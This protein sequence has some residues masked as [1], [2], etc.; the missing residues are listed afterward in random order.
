M[1]GS[2][3]ETKPPSEAQSTLR[4]IN[5][6]IAK[7]YRTISFEARRNSNRGEDVPVEEKTQHRER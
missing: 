1:G 4:L 2:R 6:K 7:A 5:I 3:Q